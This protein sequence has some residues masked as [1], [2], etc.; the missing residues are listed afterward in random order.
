VVPHLD[1]EI[2]VTGHPSI[3]AQKGSERDYAYWDP[4]THRELR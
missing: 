4:Q 3:I 2:A 1:A